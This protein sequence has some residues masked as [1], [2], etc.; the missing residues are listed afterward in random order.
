[1]EPPKAVAPSPP[2]IFTDPMKPTEIGMLLPPEP[3]ADDPLPMS[4]APL[5]PTLALPVFND[6]APD[7]PDTPALLVD[8]AA[9]PELVAVPTPDEIV[10]DPPK[11]VAPSPPS[12]F[13][14]PPL[15]LP[16]PEAR[17]KLPPL[18][19]DDDP[20]MIEA[21]TPLAADESPAKF[22]SPLSFENTR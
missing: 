11:S 2:S 13:T 1:M 10:M 3:D 8:I 20:A 9:L 7:T 17:V 5:S 18:L 21:L 14:D 19:V 12:I 6:K 4:T 15:V 22:P 16:S